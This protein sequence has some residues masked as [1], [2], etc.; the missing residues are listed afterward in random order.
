LIFSCELSL[1]QLLEEEENESGHWVAGLLG[2]AK[3][4]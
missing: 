1:R 2:V 3:E 4:L